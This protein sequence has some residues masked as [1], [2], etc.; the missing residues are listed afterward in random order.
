[1]AASI[2]SLT[3]SRLAWCTTWS[4]D[5]LN[6]EDSDHLW[7]A[8]TP[9]CCKARCNSN[10]LIPWRRIQSNHCA[11]YPFIPSATK[12]GICNA[13]TGCNTATQH[14]MMCLYICYKNGHPQHHL[15]LDLRIVHISLELRAGTSG[16]RRPSPSTSSPA[17]ISAPA[18]SASGWNCITGEVHV[19]TLGSKQPCS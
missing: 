13:A 3:S 8:S 19:T 1:M 5:A 10:L 17:K 15:E 14:K 2:I 18:P 7:S 16:P 11:L 12:E 6:S 9:T 4:S